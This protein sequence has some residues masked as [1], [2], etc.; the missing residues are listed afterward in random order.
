MGARSLTLVALAACTPPAPARPTPSELPARV[1][2]DFERAVLANK[3]AYVDL[4]DFTAVG[5]YE[6]LLHRYDLDGRM[7]NLYDDQKAQFSTEDGTPYPVTRERRNVGNF[8]P[9]LAQR[10]VGTG[11][12]VG[13]TPRSRYGRLLGQHF[14]ELPACTPPGYTTLRD[15]ANFWLDHGGVVGVKCDG[16]SGGVALVYT[17][18]PNERGYNLITIYDD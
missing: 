8:Y 10:T 9:I 14:D 3:D 6:I 15:D 13:T 12:C 18:A 2:A 7:K 16:G 11:H 17:E 5:E 1:A 4:F